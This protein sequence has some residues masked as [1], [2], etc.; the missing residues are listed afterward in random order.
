M[1]VF[2]LGAKLMSYLLG[3]DMRAA[4]GF[5][6]LALLA[7]GS[8]TCRGQCTSDQ[9]PCRLS[10][11]H[12]VKFDGTLKQFTG[13][14][15]GRV[16]ALKFSIYADSTGG[17]P[18]WQE[19]QNTQLDPQGHYE[20]MLG[21]TASDGIPS[22][23]FAVA[24]PRWLAVQ[25]LWPGE[26]EQPRVLM[27]S[28]PYALQAANAQTLGGLPASAYA[29]MPAATSETATAV[30]SSTTNSATVLP[31]G[32]ATAIA[33][34]TESGSPANAAT[35]SAVA[36]ALT[37]VTNPHIGPAGTVNTVPKFAAGGSLEDSQIT[38]VNGVAGM[39]NLANILFANRFPNGVS[40]AVAACPAMGC[41]IYALSPDV[42][43]NL[44]NI[45]PGNKSITFYLG[46]YTYTVNTITLRKGMK[47]IGMGASQSP[48]AA[49]VCTA[50]SPCN[51]TSLQSVNG[52]NPVFVIPQTNNDPATNILLSGFR[53]YGSAGNTSEDGFLLDTSSTVNTGM[54]ES[55]IDDISLN[56]FAGIGIHVKGRNDNFSAASQWLL[57]HNVVVFR[58][59]GGGNA[60]RLE[61]AVF[62]LRFVNCEFDGQHIG[63]GTNIYIGGL[64]GGTGGFPTSLVFEGLV[65][66]QANLAVQID[67]GVNLAFYGSH[68][69]S[70]S[71]A[72]QITDNSVIGTR[73]VTISDGY[74]AGNVGINGG[75]GYD[76]NVASSNVAGVVFTHNQIFGPPD[77]VVKSTNLASVVYQDNLYRAGNL[78]PTSGISSQMSPATVIDI[79]GVHSIGLN[80]SPTPITTINSGLGPGEMVTFFTLGGQVIF[81]AGGNIDLMGMT[82][83]PVTGTITMIRTDLGGQIWKIVSQWTP[84]F[85]APPPAAP[86]P[87]PPNSPN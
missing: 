17:T 58:T 55:I 15:N 4:K 75:A 64:S 11:P 79:Q 49:S 77:A 73:G 52:N 53:V 47:I 28:V 76:L 60:L 85:P 37:A 24:E 34:N 48:N 44:G 69:E 80:S 42:N 14:S 45:D 5:A 84:T 27:V 25:A 68:H 12:F 51:G 9:S 23:L 81:Q 20:V 72:Y 62:E 40:D 16:I 50:A 21:A 33:S 22:D 83:L 78:P 2:I 18:L 13:A 10:V 82:T 71:A 74:F 59:P 36:S 86:V 66:Q 41:V 70:L 46:P 43:L 65:S 19:I 31:T 38:D 8:T 29:K 57:F 63:D 56:G 32:S 61:G 7:L 54:W 1:F 39:R 87:P 67:G 3:R 35:G 30:T 6:I 26:P